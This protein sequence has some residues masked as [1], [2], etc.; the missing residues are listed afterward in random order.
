MSL[1]L[2]IALGIVACFIT[3]LLMWAHNAKWM[4]SHDAALRAI[5][6][7]VGAVVPAVGSKL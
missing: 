3:I 5:A 1:I 7:K 4:A 2:G 6:A